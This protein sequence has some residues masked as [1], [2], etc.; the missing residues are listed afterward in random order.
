[1]ENHYQPKHQCIILWQ[2]DQ[3]VH[4]VFINEFFTM[5]LDYTLLVAGHTSHIWTIRGETIVTASHANIQ[6]WAEVRGLHVTLGLIAHPCG[7]KMLLAPFLV[8]F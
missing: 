4:Y 5:C 2:K 8:H 7:K 3:H 1:M 6:Q